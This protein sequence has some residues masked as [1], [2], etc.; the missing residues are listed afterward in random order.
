MRGPAP[1]LGVPEV[2]PRGIRGESRD[3][4]T[5]RTYRLLIINGYKSH[6]SLKF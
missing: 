6:N 5:V 4:R 1:A 2:G 3:K